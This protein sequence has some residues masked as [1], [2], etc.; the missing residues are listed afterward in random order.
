[1][2]FV[3]KTFLV[4]I[5]PLFFFTLLVVAA[6]A[7]FVKVATNPVT[8]KTIIAKSE[9]YDSVV[10]GLLDE[11]G[12][13]TN[14]GDQVSLGNDIV[15]Q[16]AQ[17]TFT[18]D[19]IKQNT[20]AVIDSLYVWL[21]GETPLPDF[22]IDLT[23]AKANFASHVADGL[24]TKLASLPAC[25]SSS[26]SSQALDDPLKATCLPPGF[27]PAAE[28]A[29]IEQNMLSGTG[30]LDHPV[31]TADTFKKDNDQTSF[32]EDIK[33]IPE[34]YQKLE[35]LPYVTAAI[36]LL[37][38]LGVIFLSSSRRTGVR[39]AGI[40]L[41]IAGVLLLITAATS[42]NWINSALNSPSAT[43]TVLEDKLRIIAAELLKETVS[44]Y[45]V[46][47]G[48]YTALGALAIGLAIYK[49]P[50]GGKTDGED[51]EGEGKTAEDRID[52]KEPEDVTKLAKDDEAPA[53]SKP[54]PKPAPK[55]SPAKLSSKVQEGKPKK[56]TTKKI[57]VQ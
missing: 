41:A 2:E 40:V 47:G 5:V 24:Q 57:Q 6:N 25:T 20:E 43:N 31:L 56:P 23:Q 17:K 15:R 10:T 13:I 51:L 26:N 27:D 7:A 34:I 22:Q 19:F 1:M 28:A 55:P 54:A 14:A 18:A 9:I 48:I 32:F 45:W 35:I 39:R 4:F 16:A 21:N 33:Q 44:I 38:G 29:T 8:L 30:F 42:S 37:L 36:A 11:A 53:E 49:K 50:K 3:R 46:I 12:E 52:L